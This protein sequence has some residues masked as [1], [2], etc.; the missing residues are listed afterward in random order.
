MSEP[1]EVVEDF[2]LSQYFGQEEITL[3]NTAFIKSQLLNSSQIL[4]T[5]FLNTAYN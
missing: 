4:F 3:Y 5:H 1:T 2:V